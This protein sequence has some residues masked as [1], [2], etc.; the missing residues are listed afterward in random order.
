MR[1]DQSCLADLFC[2]FYQ[3][4]TVQSSSDRPHEKQ[5]NTQWR[6]CP[7]RLTSEVVRRSGKGH[8][9]NRLVGH[10]SESMRYASI[11][12]PLLRISLRLFIAQSAI[13]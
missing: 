9:R 6:C 13:K 10:V 4:N 2:K 12:L 1:L 7:R 3:I 5:F 8:F 11:Y